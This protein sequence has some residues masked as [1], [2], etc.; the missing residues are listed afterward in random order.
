MPLL[1]ILDEAYINFSPDTYSW[2]HRVADYDNLIVL[3]TFS[4]WAGLAGLRI[5]YGVFPE[6]LA[7]LLM[8]VKQPYN[9]SVAAEVAACAAIDQ[10]DTLDEFAR[11]IISERERLKGLL[12]EIP[13]LEPYPSAANFILCRII[14][15][16]ARQVKQQLMEQGILIRYFDRPGLRDHIR[17]SI[18]KPEQND[19]LMKAL[20]AME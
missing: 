15:R 5:G 4:K 17:F 20:R 9:V 8:K 3:R 2:I 19:I 14:G 18:G 11:K 1:V 6:A 16:S 13:W 12:R 10:V 7:P